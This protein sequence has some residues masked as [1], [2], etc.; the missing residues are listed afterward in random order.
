MNTIDFT[1]MTS[2]EIAGFLSEYIHRYGKISKIP[3]N[4]R[5]DFKGD[6]AGLHRNYDV[7]FEQRELAKWKFVK[8]S[9]DAKY[10]WDS[11]SINGELKQDVQQDLDVDDIAEQS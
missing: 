8:E 1:N 6:V 9:D 3:F 7:M 2:H 4:Q 5:P 11:I 10:L